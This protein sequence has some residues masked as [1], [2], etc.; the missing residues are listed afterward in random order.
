MSRIFTLH[1]CAG[2]ALA[3]VAGLSGCSPSTAPQAAAQAAP[4]VGVLTVQPRPVAIKTVLPGRTAP[5]VIAEVRPQVTGIV[6]SRSFREGAEVKAGAMLY[7]L[8]AATYQAAYESAKAALAKSEAS[9]QS[10]RL[11]AERSKALVAIQ[12]VSQQDYDEAVA[13]L[14]Q[15]EAD[16]AASRAA[17]DA[18]RINLA[19]TRVVAPI[20]GRIGKSAVT[21]GALV[22]ANQQTALATI[23]QLDPI[24]VDVTQ[25]SAEVLRLQRAL[26]NGELKKSTGD[27]ARVALQFEDGTQYALEGK[28]QFSDVTVDPGTGA[29]TLRAIFPNP[30][31]DLLPGMYV[32]AVIEEGV[33]EGAIVVPQQA[34]TRDTK[35]AAVAMVVGPDGK[36]ESRTLQVARTLG[37]EWLIDAGLKPGDRVIVD[38]LQRARPGA[39]V[40][41][42]ERGDPNAAGA[43]PGADAAT[44]QTTDKP[45]VPAAPAGGSPKS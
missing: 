31:G 10:A 29:I 22:T 19:Y 30:R 11:K 35:G 13:T 26:A 41:A 6:Q 24:Y 7:Q 25:S 16:V 34:V 39:L 20:S 17:V 18:A 1:L 9:M 21:A 33:R 14:R 37:N 36:V 5:T 4:Q 40:Q 32:R 3:A 23:Q 44:P 15:T 42:V 12:F 8:D 2:V 27:A 28:L 38:G 43:P 45:S